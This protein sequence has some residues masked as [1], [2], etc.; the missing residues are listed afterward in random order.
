LAVWLTLSKTVRVNGL[1]LVGPFLENV[2]SLIPLLET[3]RPQGLRAY[4]VAGR[5]DEYCYGIAQQLAELLPRY[6]IECELEVYA[7][8]DHSFPQ[9]FDGKLADALDY[10]VR[11]RGTT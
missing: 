11:G 2:E 10:V 8:L 7:D 3:H 6:D 4:L 1:I 5:R 9:G